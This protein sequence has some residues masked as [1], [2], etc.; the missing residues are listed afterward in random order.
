MLQLSKFNFKLNK[1]KSQ[2]IIPKSQSRIIKS[3]SKNFGSQIEKINS[4]SPFFGFSILKIASQRLESLNF[5]AGCG[6]MEEKCDF[7]VEI[8]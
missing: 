4:L 6:K 3:Q 5:W 2:Y 8:F 7:D 1:L